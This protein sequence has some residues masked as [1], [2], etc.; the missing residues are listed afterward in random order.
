MAKPNTFLDELMKNMKAGQGQLGA[1]TSPFTPPAAAPAGVGPTL[2]NE[3]LLGAPVA[4]AS[5]EGQG[6]GIFDFFFGNP[7]P[8][9][10]Q[11]TL[12]TQPTDQ[13][14]RERLQG[15]TEGTAGPSDLSKAGSFLVGRPDNAVDP[16]ILGSPAS[17]PTAAPTGP[18]AA[19]QSS[20]AP[21]PDVNAGQG[22]VALG[23][24]TSGSGIG[25]SVVNDVNFLQQGLQQAQGNVPQAAPNA[26][27]G[28]DATKARLGEVFGEAPQTL[29]Q[30]TAQ[31]PA[32]IAAREATESFAQAGIEAGT[33]AGPDGTFA[34]PRNTGGPDSRDRDDTGAISFNEA[35]KQ[36]PRK[37]GESV[38]AHN[39]RINAFANSGA[40]SASE[41]ERA[42][43]TKV[44]AETLSILDKIGNKSKELN[45][46]PADTARDK[47]AGT[48]LAAWDN[49]GRA[50]VTSNITSLDKIVQGLEDGQIK[51]RG[52]VDALPFAS[53]WA[54]A[55]VNPQA[56]DA[57][58]R[59]EGVIFQT[60]KETLGAQFTERE[61]KRL[62]EASY[63]P[64][65]DPATNADR[66]RD[67]SNGLK[68]A[69]EARESMLRYLADNDTLK[70]Y[71]GATPAGVMS[72]V[73]LGGAEGSPIKGDVNYQ[74]DVQGKASD[75]MAGQ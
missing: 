31:D 63:N 21:T 45:L 72:Q 75:I 36:V 46:S 25:T 29:S 49:G 26:P 37:E 20:V 62:V 15:I 60:L 44:K 74:S 41:L 24:P 28:V 57:K 39:D 53:D 42:Q 67:Y 7:T 38:S 59:V 64:M 61:G 13:A 33:S 40:S 56:Q 68:K 12:R 11:E 14:Q 23:S 16:N 8:E 2:A 70:D 19:P 3:A 65:L 71:D 22:P 5:S 32:S 51:T 73:G 10:A 9:Q 48:A 34:A 66:L 27:L 18:L 6:G 55:I 54:R 35:R 47:A 1:P 50:T 52:F 69:V 58:N 30:V 17:T 4:P 43:T